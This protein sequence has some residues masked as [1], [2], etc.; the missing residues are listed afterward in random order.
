MLASQNSELTRKN[1]AY[2]LP[3]MILGFQKTSFAAY[4]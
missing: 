2:S 3:T 1:E 4:C